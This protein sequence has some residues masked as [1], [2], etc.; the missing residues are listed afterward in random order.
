MKAGYSLAGTPMSSVSQSSISRDPSSVISYTV[1]CGRFPSRT[2]PVALM[3]PFFSST[4][5]T[6]YRE[7]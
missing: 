2:V 5:T 6:A 1:R 3:K 7:P 4:S